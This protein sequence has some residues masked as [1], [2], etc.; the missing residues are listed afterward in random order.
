MKHVINFDWLQEL[1]VLKVSH[2]VV[3]KVQIHLKFY[4]HIN[5]LNKILLN[6]FHL[7]KVKSCVEFLFMPFHWELMVYLI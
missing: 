4:L 1:Q 7:N 5:L 3:E 2:E 6:S